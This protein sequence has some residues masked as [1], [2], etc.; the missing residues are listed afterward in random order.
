[1]TLPRPLRIIIP[2]GT[3]RLGVL[4]A[5]HFHE[6]GHAVS[7]IT[8]F[9]RPR[10]WE[11]VHWDAESP[12]HWMSSLEDA[13]VVINLAGRSLHCRHT[14]ANQR[15]ILQS[16]VR[17]TELV[18][19]G[20]RECVRPPRLWINA[21]T[22][23]VYPE[24]EQREVDENFKPAGLTQPMFLEQMARAWE[25]ATQAHST[26]QTRKVQI[27]MAA[28]MSADAGGTF[29]HL[30]RLVRWG[31][32]GDM[33]SG[34]Q[35]VAWIHDF[36]FLRAIEFLISRDDVAG[37]VNITAPHPVPNHQ[38]MCNLRRAW[39]TSYFGM[40]APEW[41][42][43]TVSFVARTEPEF[44]LKSR[45]VIPGKLI[46]AGFDFDFPEWRG[47]CENLMERWRALHPD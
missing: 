36:D 19:R 41:L 18:G 20:I 16:R 21:S 25:A 5:R 40:P 47:A 24:A 4:L 7:A 44:V 1:M 3:G 15:A 29:D 23:D 2:G 17:T 8:R 38:F 34:E 11:A 42:V 9:P 33:G 30:L 37:A 6:Q 22:V 43:E 14:K 26:P 28:V 10:D 27:R 46:D 32:G 13:D 12:G 39:C 35:H 45:R 31:F